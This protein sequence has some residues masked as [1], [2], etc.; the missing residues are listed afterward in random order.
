VDLEAECRAASTKWRTLLAVYEAD[1]PTPAKVTV[2]VE[3]GRRLAIRV[4]NLCAMVV[5]ESGYALSMSG[6]E[7][8]RRTRVPLGELIASTQ[9]LRDGRPIPG[10]GVP[11]ALPLDRVFANISLRADRDGKVSR[12]IAIGCGVRPVEVFQ[13]LGHLHPRDGVTI[14]ALDRTAVAAGPDGRVAIDRDTG[15]L[16]DWTLEPHGGRPAR[17]RAVVLEADQPLPDSC[18][19]VAGDPLPG[20]LARAIARDYALVLFQDALVT[21]SEKRRERALGLA[22]AFYRFAWT[23]ADLDGLAALGAEKRRTEAERIRTQYPGTPEAEILLAAQ[24]AAKAPIREAA[25]A[26]LREDAAVWVAMAAPRSE[27]EIPALQREF[28]TVVEE[29]VCAPALERSKS[30]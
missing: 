29:E 14:R 6:A 28:A 18:F 4:E 7:G 19:A 21:P 30:R 20:P 15:A 25:A 10:R 26:E 24:S 22:R 1:S 8:V 23:D 3:R 9:A 17:I 13:W 5:D 16:L 11:A 12:A 2:A 27:H